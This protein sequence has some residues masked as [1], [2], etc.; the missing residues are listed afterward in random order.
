MTTVG[1]ATIRRSLRHRLGRW[2]LRDATPTGP[3]TV[4]FTLNGQEVARQAQRDR[5]ARA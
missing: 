1:H 3:P 2:L 5:Q 4:M